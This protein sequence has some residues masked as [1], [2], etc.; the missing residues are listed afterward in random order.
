M[1]RAVWEILQDA[2]ARFHAD[3]GFPNS[4]NI[5]YC[6]I[7]AIFPFL[8]FVFSLTGLFVSEEMASQAID[9]LVHTVPSEIIGPLEKEITSLL[10]GTRHDL[11]TVSGA[12]TLWTASR[13]IE[14]LRNGL[15]RAYRLAESR[16]VWLRIAQ[17]LLFVVAG[18]V[19]A[20]VLALTLVLGPALWAIVIEYVPAFK[21]LTLE[22]EVLR[23]MVGVGLLVIALIIG[24]KLLPARS[25]PLA[26]LWP[27][28][29]LTMVMWLIAA[30]GY[31][32]YLANFANF[33]GLYAGLG[34]VFA[35]LIFLYIS[36]AI[37]QF[38]G[39]INRAMYARRNLGR[40]LPGDPEAMK[41]TEPEDEAAS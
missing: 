40:E 35:A 13:G 39:E 19:V 29:F 9:S 1:L 17:D 8:I 36:A 18:A 32:V 22:L 23:Y 38:G 5:A 37:F 34:G 16:P 4:G 30:I 11:L 27:G 41:K 20:I 21:L 24:H 3:D 14:S 15:N 26:V 25:L 12:I 33:A 6:I 10:T 7:L 2:Y 28:I 31:S